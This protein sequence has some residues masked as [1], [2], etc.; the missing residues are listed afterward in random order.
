MGYAAGKCLI[1]DIQAEREEI[2]GGY[3][4]KVTYKILFY[5]NSD[6]DWPWEWNIA[7][8]GTMMKDTKNYIYDPEHPDDNIPIL[9][10]VEVLGTAQEVDL[11]GYGHQLQ[12]GADKV[13]LTFFQYGEVKFADLHFN[14]AESDIPEEPT[15]QPDEEAEE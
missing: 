5:P 10:V 11:D 15:Q 8:R 3:Y 7:D 1:D 14:L 12:E 6:F 13:F 9:P 2:N 4:F